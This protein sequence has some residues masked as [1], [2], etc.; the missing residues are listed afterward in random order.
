MFNSFLSPFL[1]S[2]QASFPIKYKSMK[3]ENKATRNKNIFQKQKC[4]VL[5]SLKS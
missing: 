1:N 5:N 3:D 2:S 4:I